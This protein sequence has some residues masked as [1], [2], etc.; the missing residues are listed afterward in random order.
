LIVNHWPP[1]FRALYGSDW[2]SSYV[3]FD[4]ETSGYDRERDVITQ[5][6][7]VLVQ[8]RKVVDRLEIIL[9]W[10][11]HLVVADHWLRARM[12]ALKSGM[13]ASGKHCQITY[14]RMQAE[15]RK[16]EETL[17]FYHDLFKVFT[18]KNMIFVAH[19]GYAFDEKMLAANFSG[20]G[21]APDFSFGDNT[22]LDTDCLEKAS[23]AVTNPRCVPQKG[24]TLRTYFHRVKYTRLAGIKSN[25]D[26][27]I[28]Q[29]YRLDQFGIDP[30]NMHGALNDSMCLHYLME[31]YRG[32]I[33]A[34]P[35]DASPERTV[36]RDV[37]NIV[38]IPQLDPGQRRRGQRNR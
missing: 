35:F 13:E 8:D 2:P 25:L 28:M 18:A 12:S 20:F 11:N 5:I 10:T 29:K 24:D 21:I 32:Q 26:P 36:V 17:Q 33:D 22:M 31:I 34:A 4:L 3:L 6:A 37:T 7:H 19:N 16:P 30:K 1:W 14:E 27:F 23:Q 15:G 38:N 9:D